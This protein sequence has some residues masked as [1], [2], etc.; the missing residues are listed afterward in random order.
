[1]GKIVMKKIVK[2]IISLIIILL[3]CINVPV[4]NSKAA[5]VNVTIALSASTV[6]V[7]DTV[8]ATISVSGSNI[9][10]LFIRNFKLQLRKRYGKRR[11]RYC[12]HK[13]NGS[14]LR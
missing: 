2:K 7:G 9:S 3:L 13:W 4:F 1:M 5:D 12:N 14:R 6:N 8:T 10:A 11:R